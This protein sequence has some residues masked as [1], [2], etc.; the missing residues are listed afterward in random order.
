MSGTSAATK[1]LMGPICDGQWGAFT[2]RWLYWSKMKCYPFL[3]STPNLFSKQNETSFIRG[4]YC[5]LG[6]IGSHLKLSSSD[7]SNFRELKV[8]GAKPFNAMF[9]DSRRRKDDRPW[10]ETNEIITKNTPTFGFLCIQKN[11]IPFGRLC[12]DYKVT[13]PAF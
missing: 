5:H 11:N 1:S 3:F 8:C 6:D 13:K 12:S 2:T 7:S 9:I 4:Q 10:D